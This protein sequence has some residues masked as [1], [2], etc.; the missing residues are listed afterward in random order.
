MC[1]QPILISRGG[2]AALVGQADKLAPV[3]HGSRGFFNFGK[4]AITRFTPP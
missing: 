2:L 1:A 3:A 4:L